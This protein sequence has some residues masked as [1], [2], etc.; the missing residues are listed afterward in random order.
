[1]EA[2]GLTVEPPQRRIGEMAATYLA[3]VRAVQPSGPYR[4]LGYSMGGKIAHE[5]ARRLREAGEEVELLA[6]LDIPALAPLIDSDPS[7]LP[8]LPE[9]TLAHHEASR[10]W[11]PEIFDGRILLLVAA[12]GEAGGADDPDDPAL[13]WGAFATGGV[14]AVVVPGG[15]Y[16]M[17]A[18]P[19]VASVAAALVS[20]TLGAFR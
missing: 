11:T 10:A 8:D 2:R 7:D 18:P 6:I 3:A 9:I 4:L 14:E 1:V 15:H 5:M 17:L 12:E 20:R 19:N 16:D 13:G